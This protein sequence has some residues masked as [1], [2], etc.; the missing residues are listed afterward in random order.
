M[1]R[2]RRLLRAVATALIVAGALA[3]ADGIATLAWQEPLTAVYASVQQ[4]RLDDELRTL[5]RAAP[6]AEDRR[7]LAAA[8]ARRSARAA[9]AGAA[10]ALAR[11]AEPGDPLGRLSIPALGLRTVVVEGTDGG[12]LRLGPGHY[13]GSALPGLRGTV[14]IA[15][16]RTT[17]GA[18]F[19]HVDAL[20][21]GDRIELHMPYGTFAYRVERTRIVAPTDLGA[22]ARVAYDRLVLTACHPL[23][24]ANQRIVVYA[25]PAF[26]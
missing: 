10:R 3:L 26:R 24:T 6:P 1:T 11:R 17:Y 18:P 21:P 4:A 9:A 20:E 12:D 13:A 7:V 14:A 16:H 25:R 8:H 19:R 5:E 15:G 2:R 23:Y 22:V